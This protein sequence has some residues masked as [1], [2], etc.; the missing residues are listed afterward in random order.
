MGRV[1]RSGAQHGWHHVVN[2]G[3]A[4]RTVFVTNRDRTDF[5]R[6]LGDSCERFD[7][8]VRAYCLMGNH[9]HLVV[10]CQQG[11][12]SSFM[13]YLS[14]VWTRRA[15]ER[16]GTDGPI[17]RGRFASRAIETPEYLV[18]AVRY[19]HTNPLAFVDPTKLAEYRWSSHRSY[20]GLRPT[21]EWLVC[22]D[23]ISWLGGRSGYARF[24]TETAGGDVAATSA[25]ELLAA[26]EQVVEAAADETDRSRR[27]I[28]R[29]LGAL[30][31]ARVS[32]EL[33]SELRHALGYS[34]DDA[35]RQA[36][37]R[38]RHAADADPRLEFLLEQSL[39]LVRGVHVVSDTT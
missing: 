36:R 6:L 11:G 24:V 35:A 1:A 33:A 34:T 30:M 14:G 28:T 7:V 15:N 8:R 9:Y 3:A 4:Q 39:D 10:D 22:R 26:I 5:G 27:G 13:Q 20:L 37:T 18:N 12:L 19:V 17:F 2:R 23:V 31:T 21:P 16:R 25:D 32:A 38:A 29:T